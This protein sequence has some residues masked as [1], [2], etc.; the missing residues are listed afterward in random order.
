VQKPFERA[1]ALLHS[2]QYEAAEKGFRDVAQKDPRCGIAYWGVAMSLYHVIWERPEA[3]VLK[4]GW[5]AV[6]RAESVGAKT[7]R[8][9]EYIA[10]VTAF[11]RDPEKPDYAARA[12]AY[13]KAMEQL[14]GHYPKDGEAAAF[15]ALSLLA[16]E[17]PHDTSLVNRKK[18]VAILQK[19]FAEHP[20]HPGAAH[21][22]IHACDTPQLAPLALDAARRYAK[23]AP[24]SAHALH[25]P[26]HIFTRLGLWKESIDSNL[27][28]AAAAKKATAMGIEDAGYQLHAMSFLEYA[29]LQIGRG[30]DARHVIEELKTV[31]GAKP[32]DLAYPLVQFPICYAFETHDWKK[33]GA[34]ESPAGE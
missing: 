2:F 13:S 26:S 10:A 5:E 16:A 12:M 19:L 22:L 4:K 3:A 30:E 15:F 28:S 7:N 1:V 29:Y 9:R 34:V 21:Y 11:S 25:M 18:A 8:E 27:L 24:S 33:A 20:E 14:Y 23:I 32:A 31:P 6:Q 17:P